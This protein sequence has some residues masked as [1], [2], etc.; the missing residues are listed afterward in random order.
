MDITP[1]YFAVMLFVGVLFVSKIKITKP[2]L[3]G[4]LIMIGM[5]AV[6]FAALLIFKTLL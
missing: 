4:I 5:G 2:G 6:E 3:R 1:I